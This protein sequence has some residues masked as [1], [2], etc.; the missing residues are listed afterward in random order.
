MFLFFVFVFVVVVFFILLRLILRFN[1]FTKFFT[2]S[3]GLYLWQT[4]LTYLFDKHIGL[5]PEHKNFVLNFVSQVRK[6]FFL[7][8]LLV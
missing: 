7:G 6:A 8:T 3:F 4:L 2:V 5:I 1:K